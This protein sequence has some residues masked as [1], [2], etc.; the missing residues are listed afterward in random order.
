MS[1]GERAREQVRV[2]GV[3]QGVGF[4]PFVARLAAGLGVSGTVANDADG[5]LIDAESPPE[6]LDEFVRRLQDEAPP[7]A[8][9]EQ[10]RRRPLPPAGGRG[11][12]ILPSPSG[13]GPARTLVPPDLG[14]C[15]DCERELF[16]PADRRYRHPFITCTN[17]GPRFTI[18]ERLPYDRPNT[19]MG[20]FELCPACAREYHDPTDRRYHAQPLCCPAC[21]PRLRLHRAGSAATVHGD[22]RCLRAAVADLAAGRIVA[23]KG[24]GGYHLVVRADDPGAVARLR[25]RKQ[26]GDKP[27]ALMVRDLDTARG[28]AEIDDRT[29][30][31]LTGPVRPVVLVPRRRPAA[32]RVPEPVEAVAPANPLV[33]VMLAYTGLHHLL[34]A[35]GPPVLVC[36]S[37]NVSDEPIVHDDDDALERL[38]GP[39]ADT[40]L[41]HDRAIRVPCD[42]SVVRVVDGEEVPI[43]RSRGYAP[44]PVRLPVSVPPTLAVGGELKNTCALG[45]DRNAW[46]SQHLGDMENLAALGALE[47]TADALASFHGVRPRRTVADL[48]PGYRSRRWAERRDPG[49]VTVQHHRAHVASV[50]AEHGIPPGTAVTGIAFDGTGYGDDGTIWGGEVLAGP[51][52]DLRRVGH[53]AR[54]PLP[55]GDAAVRHPA[56]V[57]LALLRSAGLGWDPAL[58][59]VVAVDEVGRRLLDAQL[60]RGVGCVPTSSMG[61]LFDGVASLLGIRHEAGYEAQ[62]A[63]ELEGVAATW[64]GP[65]PDLGFELAADGVASWVPVV[66]A[67]VEGRRAGC[68]LGALAAGFH[69]AVVDLVVAW[70]DRVGLGTV[71]LSGGVFQNALVLSGA[72]RALREAGFEVLT[73]RV[74]PPN[75][76][77]LALGQ[78]VLGAVASGGRQP[79]DDPDAAGGPR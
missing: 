28:F 65:V 36:T 7:Q 53:L 13:Q 76:A 11:F 49:T 63:I 57:A 44:L 58:P 31:V 47:R 41:T 17:C 23:V 64:A 78:L 69:A 27:F 16:D 30:R 34:L 26:R 75:D 43:R 14:L 15:A 24:L 55:G 51:Y 10:V 19:T 2:R 25:D 59:P 73:H 50:M 38:L 21:G 37:G 62:A 66:Q 79:G 42:D 74:V 46:L 56:R 20:R 29:A 70:A 61:R 22:E 32:G 8:R 67:L 39:L 6:V 33:G 77:G 35:D 60:E 72:S 40:L 18:I 5:V 4:R 54:F 68:P 48:H 1:D 9:V 71:A 45:T 52:H 3:V 12:R